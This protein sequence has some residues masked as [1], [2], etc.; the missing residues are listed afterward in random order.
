[1]DP[2]TSTL[3]PTPEYIDT[4][5]GRANRLQPRGF[6]DYARGADMYGHADYV[7]DNKIVFRFRQGI[8]WQ[9]QYKNCTTKWFATF[10]EAEAALTG[11]IAVQQRRDKFAKLLNSDEPLETGFLA[12]NPTKEQNV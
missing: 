8:R 12:G 9:A 2:R 11:M 3:Q 6:S 5:Y 7:T 4:S 10:Q 1:M